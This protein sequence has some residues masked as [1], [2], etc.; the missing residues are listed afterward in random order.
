MIYRVKYGLKMGIYKMRK[1]TAYFCTDVNNLIVREKFVFKVE[2]VAEAT[3]LSWQ[4]RM[5]SSTSVER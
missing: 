2:R 4:E 5:G 3:A 1:S